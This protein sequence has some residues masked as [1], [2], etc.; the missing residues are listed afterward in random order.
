MKGKTTAGIITR[1]LAEKTPARM[2]R[3]FIDG[4]SAREGDSTSR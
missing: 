2:L 4:M 3:A 1:A